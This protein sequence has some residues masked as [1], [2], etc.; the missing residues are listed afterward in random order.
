VLPEPSRILAAFALGLSL[1]APPGPINI[2]ILNQ[3]IRRSWFNG[4]TVGLGAATADF[5]FYLVVSTLGIRILDFTLLRPLLFALGTA[6]LVYIAVSLV[7]HS[8]VGLPNESTKTQAPIVAGY[9]QGLGIGLTNPLQIGWWLAVGITL[10]S[11]FGYNFAFGFFSGILCWVLCFSYVSSLFRLRLIPVFR[12]ISMVSAAVL[13]C[14][15]GYFVYQLI[16]YLNI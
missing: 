5:L 14:F 9:L 10:I 11:L 6:I 1:A 16:G 2:L 8:G 3:S 13:L 15:A 7:Y 12:L 4:T